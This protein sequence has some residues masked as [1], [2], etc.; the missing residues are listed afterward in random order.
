MPVIDE[1]LPQQLSTAGAGGAG[2]RGDRRDRGDVDARHGRRDGAGHERSQ[3]RADGKAA[4]DLVRAGCAGAGT[5]PVFRTARP[6][7]TIWGRW[8]DS[9][10]RSGA[11]WLR[12]WAAIVTPCSMRSPSDPACKVYLRGNELTLE[13]EE[14]ALERAKAMV[15]ELSE[16]VVQGISIGP[17]TVDAVAGVLDAD[18]ARR[19]RA[20]RR[21]LAAP[22][23]AGGAEDARPEDVRRRDPLATPSRSASARPA[24]ARPTS[25]SRW[26][27]PR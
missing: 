25:R 7:R 10:C 20:A 27:W 16:L 21:R 1:F 5:G 24:P 12:S 14:A 4:S 11:T 17:Q 6:P 19:R 2:G 3:G 18:G 22:R 13:G 8:L 23:P 9:R 15:E 26:R